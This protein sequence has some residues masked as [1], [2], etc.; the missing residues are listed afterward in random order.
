MSAETDAP[1]VAGAPRLLLRLEGAAL[2]VLAAFLYPKVSD[3]WWLFAALVLLPDLSFLGYLAGPRIGAAVY[4]AAHVT[5][6]PFALAILGF[7]LPAVILDAI[8]L[9]WLAHIGVDR[10]LGFGLKYPA[11]FAFTHLGKIG[12]PAAPG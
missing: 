5:L 2:L 6:G 11:G 8:A 10:L 7:V 1:A 4:N 12:R 3:S 9:T